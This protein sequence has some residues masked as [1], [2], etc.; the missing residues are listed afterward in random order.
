MTQEEK[1]KAYDEALEKAKDFYKGYKQ[2]DNQLYAD[3]LETI[4]PELRESEVE[5]IR[6]AILELVRQSSE[7]LD[8]QNQNNM[9]AWLEKQGEQPKEAT[10]THEVETGNGNIKAMVTEKVQLP[11]FKVKYAGS[12]YNVLEIKE[13]AGVTYYGI[14]DEPNHIDY[15]KAENCEI[16]SG[17]AIK[18]NGSPYPTKPA[19]FSEQKP[20]RMVSAEANEALYDKPTDEEMNEL[21]RT[22]YEKGRADAI[23]EMEKDWSEEDEYMLDETIQHL[24]E[25]IEIDKA[26]YCACDVQ[27]YQ[28]DIDWL[29][30]L[31]DR[32]TWRPSSEQIDTLEHF[33][34]S[35]GES[36]YASPYDNNTKLLYS[37]LEQLKKLKA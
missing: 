23:A 33:I 1:A 2:R 34:R 37:L 26:K 13:S 12:E 3:D 28:R 9:I 16:I 35:I 25:L 5:R 31:K 29:K 7:V 21:L 15:V 10:Y 18:E 27:Y 19:V 24:K 14:E 22:E 36:G 30:S 20:Q 4:F 11:K 17:Y 6:K 32:Y 8:K